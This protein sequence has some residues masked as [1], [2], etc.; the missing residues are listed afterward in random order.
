[1]ESAVQQIPGQVMAVNSFLVHGPEGVVVVDGMLTVSG[2][3]RVEVTG[4]VRRPGR[5]MGC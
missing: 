4:W 1:M 5:P 2:L 3:P